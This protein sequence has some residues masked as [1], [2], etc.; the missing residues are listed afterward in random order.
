M[1]VLNAKQLHNETSAVLDEVVKGKSFEV[2]RR[3]KV[4][5]TIQPAKK[6]ERLTWAEIM[7]PVWALHKKVKGQTPNPVL[8]ERARRRR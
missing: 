2:K 7:A 1:P 5:A 6:D 3:G 8:A 4:I